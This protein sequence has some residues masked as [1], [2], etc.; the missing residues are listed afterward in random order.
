V[1]R[2]LIFCALAAATLLAACDQ[3]PKVEPKP[4]Q[5]LKREREALEQAKGVQSTID[6]QAA[7][8]RKKLEDAEK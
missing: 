3:K 5:I 4:P 6:R 8:A 7:E 1:R 2:A